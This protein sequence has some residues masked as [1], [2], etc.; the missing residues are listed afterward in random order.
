MLTTDDGRTFQLHLPLIKKFR[1]FKDLLNITVFMV[2]EACWHQWKTDFLETS[3]LKPPSQDVN[4]TYFVKR[5]TPPKIGKNYA[6]SVKL[7]NNNSKT[8]IFMFSKDI[9]LLVSVTVRWKG[10]ETEWFAGC[11]DKIR[12]TQ[13]SKY[14]QNLRNI[15]TVYIY[16][17][18]CRIF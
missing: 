5:L 18:H 2:V 17:V 12:Y 11:W 10:S 13:S 7:N 1:Q 16:D 8:N 14:G 4:L 15:P 9:W 3:Y 6:N